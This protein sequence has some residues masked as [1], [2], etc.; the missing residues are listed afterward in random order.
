MA[1]PQK[2]LR[3][4]ASALAR[5]KV[6]LPAL[7]AAVAAVLLSTVF[8]Y[9]AALADALLT[10]LQATSAPQS[11][12]SVT[13]QVPATAARLY[14]MLPA[15]QW[16]MQCPSQRSHIARCQDPVYAPGMYSPTEAAVHRHH[17]LSPAR[18]R[19]QEEQHWNMCLTSCNRTSCQP[20]ASW[21]STT[22]TPSTT[23]NASSRT[24][25][26]SWSS[27]ACT[28]TWPPATPRSPGA[29]SRRCG[30]E[31]RTQHR[32]QGARPE[33]GAASAG[34]IFLSRH[35]LKALMILELLCGA[36]CR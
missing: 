5:R 10:Q 23:G 14:A 3:N 24:S 20:G 22:S 4:A 31:L 25:S 21:C 12:A 7:L 17:R 6:L 32:V 28:G 34:G 8:V 27:A 1:V 26:R 16:S 9:R 36:Q 18:D 30:G 19:E 11:A 15:P 2:G 35:L 13:E 29:R 33:V